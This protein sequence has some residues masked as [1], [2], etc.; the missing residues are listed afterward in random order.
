MLLG[1]SA[2][3]NIGIGDNNTLIGRYAGIYL[4]DV[5]NNV[6][7]GSFAGR[8]IA[9]GTTHN[10]TSYNSIYL[11]YNTKANAD[12]D[13]NEIVIGYNAIGKGSNTVVLGNTSITKTYLRGGIYD[14]DVRS[15]YTSEQ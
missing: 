5:D 11:G 13:T 4:T 3:Y 1:E 7:I 12:G 9:D 8:Y 14:R 2:G 6:G 10:E 15:R